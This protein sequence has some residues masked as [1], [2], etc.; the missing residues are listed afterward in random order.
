MGMFVRWFMG[1]LPAGLMAAPGYGDPLS[2]THGTV[3]PVATDQELQNAVTTVNDIGAPATILIADGTYVLQV[4]MLHL[5]SPNL[6]VRSASGERDRVVLRGPDEGPTASLH[7]VFLI[8]ADNITIADLTFG[9]CRYHGIQVRGEEPYNVAGLT[10]HNCRIVNCNEQFI[11]GSSADADPVGTTDGVIENCVFEF[12]GGWAYQYYTGGIDIHKGVNW[13]VRDN[14]FRNIRV[15]EG[16]T[17]IA[18]HAIHFWKRCPARPQ[19]ITVERNWIINCDRGIGYGLTSD[20]DGGHRGGASVIRNNFVY[21]NGEGSHT[22][23]GIGLENADHVTVD[24]N[25]VHVETYWAPIEYRFGG[26]TNLVFRNN[27]VNSPIRRRDNA[28]LA[29]LDG[30]MEATQEEWFRDLGQGDLHLLPVATDA[31]DKGT[32]LGEVVLDIDQERRP[33]GDGPD[34][35]ADEY[36]PA[37]ADSDGDAMNDEW[38]LRHGLDPM[39][40]AGDMGGEGDP[41]RDRFIN[42]QEFI[43]DTAPTD[44]QD[45]LIIETIEHGEG[46]LVASWRGSPDR[47]YSILSAE[48]LDAPFMIEP[49]FAGV[50]G[51]GGLT[52]YTNTQPN[53]VHSYYRLQ[54]HLP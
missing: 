30:N 28:P 18:E 12:T 45:Y 54:V 6:I 19:N 44:E 24:H 5:S 21:N 50:R 23:V 53:Q 40:A 46:G 36:D 27:L 9:Y 37:K 25:T 8:S 22:D 49:G 17:G 41:D 42:Y 13:I 2:V 32:P 52:F 11:K 14:L 39:S 47:A 20:P 31:L 26:S 38:E 33:L 3:Y 29:S 35:G 15:S 4:P 16:Q 10:V 43:A 7:H 48:A 34:V 51:D 1:L